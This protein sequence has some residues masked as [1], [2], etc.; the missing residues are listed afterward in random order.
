M[1]LSD[2]PELP[3][4]SDIVTAQLQGVQTLSEAETSR[5][6]FILQSLQD[7]QQQM[8]YVTQH[9]THRASSKRRLDPSSEGSSD[10]EVCPNRRLCVQATSSSGDTDDTPRK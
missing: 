5:T 4:M 7:L 2:F 10:T 6:K 9:S 8:D 1:S 3:S